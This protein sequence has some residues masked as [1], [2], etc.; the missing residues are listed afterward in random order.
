MDWKP[1][2]VNCAEVEK[3]AAYAKKLSVSDARNLAL[4]TNARLNAQICETLIEIRNFL[5]AQV[6]QGE[7]KR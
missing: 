6:R 4:W 7:R 5:A 2:K 3:L 1:V